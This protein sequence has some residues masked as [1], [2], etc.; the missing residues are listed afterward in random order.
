MQLAVALL[1]VLVSLVV[2]FS[3]ARVL[4]GSALAVLLCGGIGACFAGP[5]GC[6]VGLV[7][8][9]VLAPLTCLLLNEER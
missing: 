4:F 9:L 3:I 7:A 2:L 1:V 8:G 5:P 6:G